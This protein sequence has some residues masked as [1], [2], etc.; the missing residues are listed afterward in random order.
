M[1]ACAAQALLHSRGNPPPHTTQHWCENMR[2]ILTTKAVR[3]RIGKA[4]WG[5]SLTSD[6]HDE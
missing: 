2:L 4:I 5:T 1:T 6:G 3:A